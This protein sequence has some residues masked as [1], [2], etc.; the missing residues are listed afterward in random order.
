MTDRVLKVWCTDEEWCPM[1]ATAKIIGK[2][3][4]PVIVHRLLKNGEMGFNE[5]KNDLPGISNKV[6]SESLEDLEEK[7][8]IDKQVISENPKRVRY[9]LTEMG[10]DLEKTINSMVE[11]GK[12]RTA[13]APTEEESFKV[14]IE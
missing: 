7:D 8:I 5:I 6:L 1:T 2:K 12:K 11:W 4:H 14:S 9:T 13:E 10:K 3:W